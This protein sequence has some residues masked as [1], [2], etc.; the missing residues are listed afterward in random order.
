MK[1]RIVI[2]SAFLSPFRSGAEACAE[3]V[4]LRLSDRYDI[5]ILTSRLRA[6]LPAEDL[7]GQKVRVLRLGSGKPSD[8]WMFPLRASGL[9]RELQP[10]LTHAILESY[11]GLALL[12]SAYRGVRA[13]RIL[14]CQST[15]TSMLLKSM[16][17]NAD[18]VTVI[19]SVLQ[20]RAETLGRRD[21]VLIPNGIPYGAIRAACQHHRRVP[22]R[23]LYVGRL[24]QMKGVDTLLQAFQD[25]HRRNTGA[26]L[27]VVGS[28]SL[29]AALRAQAEKL[30]L[31]ESVRFLGYKSSYELLTEYAQAEVFCGLSRSE[32]LGNVFLEA[33][34]AGCAVVATSVGGIPD[35]IQNGR[36]GLLIAP[37]DPACAADTIVKL[38][39]DPALRHELGTQ[40]VEHAKAYDWDGIAERYGETYETLLRR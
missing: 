6:D 34:A 15:N 22:G 36:N 12:I 2:L 20:R 37:D 16:H 18:R 26:H 11:A 13:K 29:E 23:V 30:R 19:S 14:T 24:E 33:Q 25:V 38:L 28:G 35:A 7:L 9:L 5:T 40:G 8:K 10:D 1:P 4:A 32:A 21:A 3:E 39:N 27:H 17:R 31:G